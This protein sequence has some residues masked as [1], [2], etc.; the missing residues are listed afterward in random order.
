VGLRVGQV[1]LMEEKNLLPLPEIKLHYSSCLNN[2][3]TVIN[4]YVYYQFIFMFSTKMDEVVRQL[5]L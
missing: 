3:H 5:W 1:G 2:E 4:K